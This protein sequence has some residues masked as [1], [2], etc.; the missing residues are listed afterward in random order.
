MQV[1]AKQEFNNVV[2]HFSISV[3]YHMQERIIGYQSRQRVFI[4]FGP[5]VSYLKQV[6]TNNLF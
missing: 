4:L 3:Q 1:M 6:E 2:G 5:L